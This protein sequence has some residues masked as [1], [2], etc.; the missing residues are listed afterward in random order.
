MAFNAIG[1]RLDHTLSNIN[2]LYSVLSLQNKPCYLLS[3]L[4]SVCLLKPVSIFDTLLFDVQI[5]ELFVRR[6]PRK[7][8]G[9][10]SPTVGPL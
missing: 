10:N 7:Y 5:M 6:L 9:E 1:G 2:T 3:D 4:D 8:P